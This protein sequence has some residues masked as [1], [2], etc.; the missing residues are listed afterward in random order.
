MDSLV[1]LTEE[2]GYVVVDAL[3]FAIV[4]SLCILCDVL[5]VVEQQLALH[6]KS[7]AEVAAADFVATRS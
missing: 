1:V 2:Y 7:S 4:E 5:F 6:G 3:D